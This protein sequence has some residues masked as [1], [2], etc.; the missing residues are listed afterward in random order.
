ME[1]DE[2]IK[3]L[4][5]FIKA[6]CG[7]NSVYAERKGVSRQY[8]NAVLN[9]NKPPSDAMLADLGLKKKTVS[10]TTFVSNKF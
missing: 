1:I 9:K 4:E 3:K 8:L 5:K 10:V 6:Q 7:R 2:V